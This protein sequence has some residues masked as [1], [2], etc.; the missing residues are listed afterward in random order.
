MLR[1]VVRPSAL[2]ASVVL[3]AALLAGC[4]GDDEAPAGEGSTPEEVMEQ[5]KATLDETSGLA[6]SL[7]TDDLPDGVT[8]IVAAEG[9]GTRAPAFEGSITV[10]LLGQQVEVPVVAV[11]DTVHAQVP[12][13]PGWQEIDPDEY[14]APDP[15]DLMSPD[16]GFSSILPAT[17]DLEEGESVRGGADNAEVLTEYTG[18][19]PDTAVQN[20][21]PSASG[22]FDAT[23]TVSADGELR[24]AVLTGVFY[25]D[26]PAMTYT[27]GFDDYGTDRDIT[28]P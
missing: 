13:T 1:S 15:A 8:G 19:V 4:S 5:A 2:A 21:I 26:S 12:L 22:D 6:I 28:A 27:I 16:A 14:G 9:V 17:T 3:S 20:V 23:Y 18:T 7:R 11:D 24:T 25:A 10:N